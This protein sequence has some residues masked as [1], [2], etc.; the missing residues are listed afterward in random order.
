MSAPATEQADDGKAPEELPSRPQLHIW[1]IIVGMASVV[2]AVAGV[3]A[4]IPR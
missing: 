2:S 3:L 4:L 1:V